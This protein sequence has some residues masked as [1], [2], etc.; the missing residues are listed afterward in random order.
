MN[1]KICEKPAGEKFEAWRFALTKKLSGE[2]IERIKKKM[3]VV[4]KV[5]PIERSSGHKEGCGSGHCTQ[6]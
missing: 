3:N 4:N 2:Q 5:I 1:K 6:N